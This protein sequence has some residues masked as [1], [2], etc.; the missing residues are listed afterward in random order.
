VLLTYNVDDF[1]DLHQQWQAQGRTHAGIFIIYQ[2][3]IV[4]KDMSYRDMIRAINNL[5][6]SGIPI[7][8]EVHTLNHWQ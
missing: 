8:N 3:N 1:K 2:E 6:A 7:A 4:G 5:L